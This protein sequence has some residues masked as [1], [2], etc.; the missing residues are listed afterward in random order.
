M[1]RGQDRNYGKLPNN[2]YTAWYTHV[3]DAS[4]G[5]RLKIQSALNFFGLVP[6]GAS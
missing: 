3:R 2:L 5:T 1:R 4:G 6:A